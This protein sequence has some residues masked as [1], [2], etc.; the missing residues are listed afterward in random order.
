M[1]PSLS[2]LLPQLGDLGCLSGISS[3]SNMYPEAQDSCKR[4]WRRDEEGSDR[5]NQKVVR[6]RESPGRVYIKVPGKMDT[7][8]S[9]V[10]TFDGY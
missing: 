4:G 3:V 6:Q 9:R 5:Q 1:W 2:H 10:R 7:S 8:K